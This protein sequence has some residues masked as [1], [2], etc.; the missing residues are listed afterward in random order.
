MRA[1]VFFFTCV[2]DLRDTAQWG[3]TAKYAY[4]Q[5]DIRR[6]V[7]K[8][9]S[10]DGM[11][12]ATSTDITTNAS[13]QITWVRWFQNVTSHNKKHRTF[14]YFLK[15]P[16]PRT[17][18]VQENIHNDIHCT[19][20]CSKSNHTSGC[21]YVI[22]A[23]SSYKSGTVALRTNPTTDTATNTLKHIGFICINST[24]V[25]QH[26][27]DLIDTFP[28]YYTNS[29]KAGNL[30]DRDADNITFVWF[31]RSTATTTTPYT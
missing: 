10:G 5:S 9:L 2:T 30:H 19:L 20:T 7:A 17:Y 18:R 13:M 11:T 26:S 12:R 3:S 27:D 1:N 25:T 22:S 29:T 23:A 21:G 31:F 6:K 8:W 16:H 14:V 4:K 15:S 28:N 24:D